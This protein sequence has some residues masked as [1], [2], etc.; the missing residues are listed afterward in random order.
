[1]RPGDWLSP[2]E[3][4]PSGGS[5]KG[6]WIDVD[7]SGPPSRIH[8][9]ASRSGSRSMTMGNKG[10]VVTPERFASGMMFE[11]HMALIGTRGGKDAR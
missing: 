5:G 6:Q 11:Q 2:V 10:S 8:Y 3:H 4:A 7:Y 1:M 9:P